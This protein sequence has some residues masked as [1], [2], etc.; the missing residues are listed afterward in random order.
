MGWEVLERKMA[1]I[2]RLYVSASSMKTPTH[3]FVQRREREA[4]EAED[5][6]NE[7]LREEETRCVR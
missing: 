5:R 4:Q 7:Q 2:L 1:K 6:R 3:Y